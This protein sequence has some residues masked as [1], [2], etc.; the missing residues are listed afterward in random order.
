MQNRKNKKIKKKK[1]IIK[2]LKCTLCSSGIKEVSYKDVY[3]LKKFVSRRG[4]IV[5]RV[6][7]GN[8]AKHQRNITLS[9][10]RARYM[11]LMPYTLND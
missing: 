9:I 4:K 1:R 8:C 5:P 10:K 6:R 3:R 7:T 2:G 11:A